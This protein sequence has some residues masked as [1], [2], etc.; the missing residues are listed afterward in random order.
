LNDKTCV[1]Y[2]ECGLDICLNMEG[3]TCQ[4]Y[5]KKSK[6]ILFNGDMVK[7][8]LVGRKTQTRRI[9][10]NVHKP[11]FYEIREGGNWCS[12]PNPNYTWAGFY[13]DGNI[14]YMDGEKRIDPCYYKLPY[15]VGDTLW[16]RETWNYHFSTLYSGYNYKADGNCVDM[17]KWRPSIHMPRAAARLFLKVTDVRVERLQ[18]I[19][20]DGA[21]AEGT[22]PIY[23][24]MGNVYSQ[25]G[26]SIG[27]RLAFEDLWNGIYH[28][29]NDN[30]WVWVIEF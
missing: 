5:E 18:D 27:Y 28:N 22:Y 30:P 17:Q 19:T 23:D 8:I 11:Y 3:L 29:W 15:K 6:P 26:Y 14:F 2:E 12:N 20:E 9:V 4:D 10:K 16:V 25:G 21:M 24:A 1:H 7:A 13:D